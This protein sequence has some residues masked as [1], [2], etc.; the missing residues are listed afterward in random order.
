MDKPDT[1]SIIPPKSSPAAK[2]ISLKPTA[3]ILSADDLLENQAL[4]EKTKE[5]NA[6]PTS[7]GEVENQPVELESLKK[8]WHTFAITKKEEG[9]NSTY[10]LLNQEISFT[11][12]HKIGIKLSNT[13]QQPLLEG[14]RTELTQY[15]RKQLKNQN[16]VIHAELIEM[17]S[18][19]MIY[20][21]TEKFNYLAKK[22]PELK[23]LKD[24][25]GLDDG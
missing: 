22:Y 18:E 10:V 8:H 4:E 20:T 23:N 24:R 7:T 14:V 11:D 21:N 19:E 17:K 2:K 13:V 6:Q 16:L 12:E 25:L 1:K 5:E 3:K 15:L 9:K